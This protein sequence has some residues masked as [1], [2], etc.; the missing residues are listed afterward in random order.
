MEETIDEYEK[1]IPEV[2]NMQEEDS[3]THFM[4]S[5]GYLMR[6]RRFFIFCITAISIFLFLT[7]PMATGANTWKDI[8]IPGICEFKIPPTLEIQNQ[9]YREGYP[10][11]EGLNLP[12]KLSP[13]NLIIQP[14]GINSL[15]PQALKKYSRIL[16]EVGEKASKGDFSNNE[17]EDLLI[18]GTKEEMQMLDKLLKVM[19]EAK[20]AP[21]VEKGL[22]PRIS[23]WGNLEIVRLG[24]LYAMQISYIRE[25]SRGNPDVN[26]MVYSIPIDDLLYKITFSYRTTETNLWKND[27]EKVRKTMHFFER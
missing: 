8:V 17:L 27:F 24:N 10:E 9:K 4:R 7:P 25:G 12:K 1:D 6:K 14:T 15:D 18:H 2:T 22:H 5:G 19:I 3:N 21:L 26:V 16:C 11:I 13:S 23:C 20:I